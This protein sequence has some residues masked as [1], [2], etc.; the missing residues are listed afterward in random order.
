MR[1]SCF[2]LYLSAPV[3]A[4][5]W[6]LFRVSSSLLIMACTNALCVEASL[7]VYIVRNLYMVK[8]LID[9]ER[10]LFLP[11]TSEP[12]RSCAKMAGPFESIRTIIAMAIMS[13]AKKMIMPSERMMSIQRL[14][15]K[16]IRRRR[17]LFTLSLGCATTRGMA[18]LET[19]GLIGL[20]TRRTSDAI[21]TTRIENPTTTDDNQF[22]LILKGNCAFVI[23]IINTL[24][25]SRL[26][27]FASG[28]LVQNNYTTSV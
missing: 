16:Y 27:I 2:I 28:L 24:F 23:F 4:P 5:P 18:G 1:G 19:R 7:L 15:K 14:R 26:A 21:T 10:R 12:M 25:F 13:G 6:I 22:K 17:T 11:R 8:A 3:T 9:Q 20:A